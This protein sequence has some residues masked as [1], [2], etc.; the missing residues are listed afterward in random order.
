MKKALVVTG[1]NTSRPFLE[2]EYKREKFDLVIGVDSGCN[3]LYQA[4]IMPNL[5]IGDFDSVEPNVLSHFKNL[6]EEDAVITF[7]EHKDF[8]DTELALSHIKQHYD[9]I[10]QVIILGAT[11][12]RIDHMLST[13]LMASGYSKDLDI[14]LKDD[15]NHISCLTG[16]KE[17]SIIKEQYEYFSLLAISDQV[18]GVTYTGAKYPL[19]QA[20]VSRTDTVGVSNE[21]LQ[22]Q[23]HLVFDSGTCLLIKSKDKHG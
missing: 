2:S 9:T 6:L 19:N 16:P 20:T 21:W 13:I 4:Q 12:N 17:T 10:N 22:E 18:T 23:V 11:G 15:T 5:I 1:G 8:T 3:S 14:V 7:N